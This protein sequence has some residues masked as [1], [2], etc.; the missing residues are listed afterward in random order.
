MKNY[1]FLSKIAIS[2]AYLAFVALAILHIVN[3]E[4]DPSWHMVSEYAFGD[5]GWMLS[6]FFI[7]WGTA[8][9]LTGINL[10]REAKNWTS[11]VA[12]VLL[13]VSGIGAIMGGLFDV[14]QPLHGLAF[15]LGVPTLPIAA[16]ILLSYFKRVY[17]LQDIRLSVSTH[18]TWISVIV[19][20][21]TLFLFMSGMTK[22][23][24]MNTNVPTLLT[25]LPDGVVGIVGY[26]N[27]FLVVSYL[28]WIIV[29]QMHMRTLLS[30]K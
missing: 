11:K 26:A 29:I 4:I 13:T 9:I 28:T 7:C 24:G 17:G 10:F 5:Y 21:G 2:F 25:V 18:A 1:L 3:S 20:M 19:T 23:G 12:I 6:I 22:A 14:R 15:G 16:L 27:R 30:S 8:S